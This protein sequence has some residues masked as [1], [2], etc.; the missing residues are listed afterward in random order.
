MWQNAQPTLAK[1][2]RPLVVEVVAGYAGWMAENEIPKLFV[3]AEPGA[4][5]VGAQREFCRQWPNQ[6][7]VTVK[8]S[9]FIQEDCGPEIG[10]AIADWFRRI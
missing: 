9:H 2:A 1:S 3:N 7:E 4:I 8:G 5:L 10:R 6:T